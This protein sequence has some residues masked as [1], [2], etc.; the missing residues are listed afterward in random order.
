ML[1]HSYFNDMIDEGYLHYNP[2]GP[3]K[4]SYKSSTEIIFLTDEEIEIFLRAA[5][6]SR[7]SILYR[8]ALDTGMRQGELLGLKWRDVDLQ[9]KSIYVRRQFGADDG[10]WKLKDVKTDSSR[11][12]ISL[13]KST[14]EALEEQRHRIEIES[15]TANR[16][17]ENDLVFPSTVGTPIYPSNLRK[18]FKRVLGMANV[19]KLRFHDLRHTAASLWLRLGIHPQIVSE[20]LGHASIRIT[21]DTYSHLIPSLQED[22][23]KKV[24]GFLS[25]LDYREDVGEE[26]DA[27]AIAAKLQ[28]K[29]EKQRDN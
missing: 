23:A 26:F 22:A 28:R 17:E 10:G 12:R 24:D 5:E 27:Q 9:N 21:L 2:V 25:E 1:L 3:V 15:S 20:R 6:S 19:P 7:L 13:G 14:C 8:I 29:D 18:N 16:W 4:V 11:R